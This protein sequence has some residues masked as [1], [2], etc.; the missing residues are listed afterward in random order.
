MLR[1]TSINTKF[2]CFD[3]FCKHS[4]KSKTE[5][6]DCTNMR[7]DDIMDGKLEAQRVFQ[8]DVK[9]VAVKSES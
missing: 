6:Y 2:A 7:I 1:D 5:K 4:V 3:D 8:G 9:N